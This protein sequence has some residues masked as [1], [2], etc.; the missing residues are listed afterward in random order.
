MKDHKYFGN[1]RVA[2]LLDGMAL[3]DARREVV[4]QVSGALVRE[5]AE[6][7]VTNQ[8]HTAWVR[9]FRS[10]G[11]LAGPSNY[12]LALSKQLAAEIAEQPEGLARMHFTRGDG[13]GRGH[14]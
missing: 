9:A 13:D 10:A 1:L 2:T 12:I 3:P 7:L 5:G 8:S 11:Y 6:L 4:S 14:L